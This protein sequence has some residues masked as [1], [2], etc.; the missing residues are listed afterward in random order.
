MPT[1]RGPP[2]PTAYIPLVGPFLQFEDGASS[3]FGTVLV[4]SNG[5]AQVTGATLFVLGL[6]WQRPAEQPKAATLRATPLT[7][8]GGAGVGISG[9]L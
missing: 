7:F 3:S 2:Y 5:S 4:L 8:A 9:E 1:R 6:A